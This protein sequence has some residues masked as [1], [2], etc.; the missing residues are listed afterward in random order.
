MNRKLFWLGYLLALVGVAWILWR[1]RQE[2]VRETLE[3]LRRQSPAFREWPGESHRVQP[4]AQAT[5]RGRNEAES[6]NLQEISGIGPTY[7]RRLEQ[8]G[9]RTFRQLAALSA[10]E[11]RE[12]IK[13]QPWQGDVESWI[14]QARSLGSQR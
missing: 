8:A 9:I 6:D 4:I 1:Q 7:A 2:E 14:E 10:D 5:H 13:L 12:R 3:R 11:I